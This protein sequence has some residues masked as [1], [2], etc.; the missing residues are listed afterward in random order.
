MAGGK[1]QGKPQIIWGNKEVAEILKTISAAY[2]AKAEEIQIHLEATAKLHF[3]VYWG[4]V[5][6]M[7]EKQ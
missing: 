6:L 2:I 3:A 1:G 7:L 4:H 5:P